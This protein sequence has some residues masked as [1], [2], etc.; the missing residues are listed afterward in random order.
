[1]CVLFGTQDV[2][3]LV[4]DGYIEVAADAMEVQR[5]M[6]RETRK[7]DHMALFYIHQCVDMNVFEKIAD[8]TTMKATW[9]TLVQFYGGDVKFK[10]VKLQSLCKQYENLNMKNNEKIHDYI[11]KVTDHK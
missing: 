5:N 6:H 10:K 2:S 9:E 11:S 7:K 1:M 3:D 8:S 4:N